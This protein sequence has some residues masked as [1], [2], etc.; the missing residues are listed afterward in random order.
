MFIKNLSLSKTFQNSINETASGDI[1]PKLMSDIKRILHLR[2]YDYLE[3]A[4]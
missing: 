3:K 2:Y 1:L 4:F